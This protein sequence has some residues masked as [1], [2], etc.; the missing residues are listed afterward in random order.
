MAQAST[1]CGF[2][3][4]LG[5]PNAGKSTLLNAFVGAKIIP[6]AGA[7]L[8]QGVLV[9]QDGRI[10]AIGPADLV[11]I[12]PGAQRIDVAGKVI[13]PGLVDTH[14]HIGGIGGADGSGPIQPGVRILDSIN[15]HSSGFKL[16][17]A[18]G[19]TTLNIMPGS[20]HLLSGQTIYLKIRLGNTI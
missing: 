19:L 9:V 11:S 18:G 1:R 14:S 13:M 16:A 17:L 2:V 20:G 6:V 10:T 8:D 15:V 5:A 12:P 3:A 4:L 7:E